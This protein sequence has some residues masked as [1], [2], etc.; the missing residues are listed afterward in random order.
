MPLEV[1]QQPG[2]ELPSADG[3]AM[4]ELELPRRAGADAERGVDVS[5]ETIRARCERFGQEFSD[6]GAVVWVMPRIKPT[7]ITVSDGVRATT[8]VSLM[9]PQAA[10]TPINIT[11]QQGTCS[12][13]RHVLG[14]LAQLLPYP[15][16]RRHQRFRA[17]HVPGALTVFA[18]PESA[19]SDA[20]C[21]GSTF[22]SGCIRSEAA[23]STTDAIA[24]STSAGIPSTSSFCG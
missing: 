17:L 19:N 18:S 22:H 6:P 5:Y 14:T 10:S 16:V 13:S 8:P 24:R 23:L 4:V 3:R 12:A 9:S 15:T 2:G 20:S 7:S 11:R 21:F 1:P